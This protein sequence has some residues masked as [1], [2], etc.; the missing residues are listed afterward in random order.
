MFRETKRPVPAVTAE[1]VLA[2]HTTF[3]GKLKSE[4]SL[5]FDGE[6]EGELIV[7]GDVVVG[8]HG[9]VRGNIQAT[10][11]IVAGKVFGNVDTKGRLEIL[12]SGRVHGDICVGS[13]IIDE[14][15]VLEGKSTVVSGEAESGSRVFAVEASAA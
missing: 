9:N 8:E 13:L 15:G 4:G 1:T 5:R 6:L 11:V 3:E 2:Q 10:N 14:G 7:N 12:A